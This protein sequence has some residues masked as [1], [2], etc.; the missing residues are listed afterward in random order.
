M[1]AQIKNPLRQLYDGKKHI[2]G[3]Q[4]LVTDTISFNKMNSLAQVFI[5]F[6]SLF[7]TQ[8]LNKLVQKN[9]KV[10]SSEVWY[11]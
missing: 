9:K 5:P 8:R 1:T 10:L 4:F 3:T 7:K 11:F 6:R 2:Q